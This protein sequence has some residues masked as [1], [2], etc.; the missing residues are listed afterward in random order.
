M[1]GEI[2]VWVFIL[3]EMLIFAVLFVTYLY[4][5]GN[6]PRL[7]EA[8]QQT[9]DQSNGA[10]LTFVLLMGSLLVVMAVR[11]VRQGLRRTA[12]RLRSMRILPPRLKS[13][14]NGLKRQLR[15]GT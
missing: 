15:L 9:L 10:V 5:R 8:S 4:Y 6:E 1:P 11:A 14:C 3:G 12:Q 7:F 2:G 13:N